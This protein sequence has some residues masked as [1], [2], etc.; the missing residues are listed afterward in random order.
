MKQPI[1]TITFSSEIVTE[2]FGGSSVSGGGHFNS[3]SLVIAKD[4][5]YIIWN[6]GIIAPDEDQVCIGIRV[7]DGRLCD[8]D[9]SFTLP[10]QAILLLEAAG[11][12]ASYAKEEDVC[13]YD[14][15]DTLKK[16]LTDDPVECVNLGSGVSRLNEINRLAKSVINQLKGTK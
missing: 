8:Y 4:V 12:D 2:W 7:E 11:I 6:F 13:H 14:L 10:K 3:M 9:G 5:G 1:A 15:M 16:C